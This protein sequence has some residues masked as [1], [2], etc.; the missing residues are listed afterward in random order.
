MMA[1]GGETTGTVLKLSSGESY[2][3]SSETPNKFTAF[4]GKKVHVEGSLTTVRGIERGLRR[5]LIVDTIQEEK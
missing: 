1:I 3:L 4:S 5:I 2:E